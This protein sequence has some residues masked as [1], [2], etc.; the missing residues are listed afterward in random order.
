MD[1]MDKGIKILRLENIEL[2]NSAADRR[3]KKKNKWVVLL[4]KLVLTT[5]LAKALIN[6]KEAVEEAKQRTKNTREQLRKERKRIAIITK[7]QVQE[8]KEAQA[9]ATKAK[10]VADQHKRDLGEANRA[11]KRAQKASV[12]TGNIA[13]RKKTVEAYM[14]AAQAVEEAKLK[15]EALAILQKQQEESFAEAIDAI[16]CSKVLKDTAK[17]AK[18]AFQQSTQADEE[19]DDEEMDDE[20]TDDEDVDNKDEVLDKDEDGG[21]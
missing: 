15:T 9:T 11:A 13:K 17:K 14:A 6:A 7:G 12:T 1:S 18:E 16:A 10:K 19:V 4:T 21:Y 3:A 8:R 2:Y 5:K 20:E